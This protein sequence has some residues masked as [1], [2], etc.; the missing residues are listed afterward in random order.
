MIVGGYEVTEEIARGAMG[1]VYR[2]YDT[3]L[4]QPVAIKLLQRQAEPGSRHAQRFQREVTALARLRHP[5]IISLHSA[6]EHQGH[7]YLVMD[8]VEGESLRQ[9]LKID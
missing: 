5:H 6:G 7:P 2:A 8:L 3:R 4:G 1:V 9:R